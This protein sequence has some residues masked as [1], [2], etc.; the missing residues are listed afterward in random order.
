[1]ESSR[2]FRVEELASDDLAPSYD[3]AAFPT[4]DP[5]LWRPVAAGLWR[6]CETFDGTYDVQDLCDVL[7]FLAV[8]EENERRYAE[9]RQTHDN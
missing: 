1:M 8:K 4:L 2:F 9:W 7:E 3:P 5:L 6:Q